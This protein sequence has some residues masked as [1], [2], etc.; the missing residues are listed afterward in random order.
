M[1]TRDQLGELVASLQQE[2]D[3]LRLRIHLAGMEARDEYERLSG[4]V[5]QLGEQFEPVRDATEEAAGNVFAA[6]MLAAGEMKSGFERVRR[7][8]KDS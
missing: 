3:E 6:L 1:P 5:G 8:I 4:K 7:A 2:R